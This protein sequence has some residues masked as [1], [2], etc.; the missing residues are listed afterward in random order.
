MSGRHW[1]SLL[2][3]AVIAAAASAGFAI[4]GGFAVFHGI[5]A[6]QH[7]RTRADRLDPSVLAAIASVNKQVR[8]HHTPVGLLAPNSSRLVRQFAGGERVYA[9]A[10]T[11]GF[12]CSLV[13]RLRFPR[14]NNLKQPTFD[15]GC[16]QGGL[17]QKLPTTIA[18][19]KADEKSPTFSWG[20]AFDDVIALSWKTA[21]RVIT[22]PVKHNAWAYTGNAS[23]FTG[24]A[25]RQIT[26]H[27]ADGSTRQIP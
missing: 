16:S 15:W 5:S 14:A 6:A 19:F 25:S 24:N 1:G 17:T 3:A 4:A 11:G 26:V 21:G 13:E 7:P 9:V 22:I 20:I 12:L 2:V 27:F 10:A 23:P 18:S 8:L